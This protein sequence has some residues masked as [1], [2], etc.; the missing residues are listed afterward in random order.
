MKKQ[1]LA[2][3]SAFA[4]CLSFVACGGG[5]KAPTSRENEQ[6]GNNIISAQ[7]TTTE[8]TNIVAPTNE[9]VE[10]K[11]W[12]ETSLHG[13]HSVGNI[14][15]AEP[16]EWL[17][18]KSESNI[19]YYP[20]NSS[21]YG[22]SMVMVS[23][24]PNPVEEEMSD[25]DLNAAYAEYIIGTAQG[26]D[27]VTSIDNV[28]VA[29]VKACKGRAR[30]TVKTAGD[31]DA[32]IYVFVD[33]DYIYSFAF[34]ELDKLSDEIIVFSA[35]LI[36]TVK[37]KE[38]SPAAGDADMLSEIRPEFKEALDSYEAFFVE[39]CNFMEKYADNPTDLALLSDYAAYLAQYA[40]TMSKLESLDDGKMNDAETK[41]YLEVTG[42]ITQ[43][44]LEVSSAIN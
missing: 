5:D 9:E 6:L 40:E 2:L 32:I 41:Y 10:N 24:V 21:N 33:E 26:E 14:T 37:I 30:L 42:R 43:M 13:E 27:M 20:Y 44:L 25:E 8:T 28:T 1:L 23:A 12:V 17:S 19:W 11:K 3:F 31:Y 22:D 15:Y 4:L 29:G 38:S 16:I 39:Y 34:G 35:E 18:K 36:E 7:E